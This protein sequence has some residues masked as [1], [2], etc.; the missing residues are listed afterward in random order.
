[1]VL[2]QVQKPS[3][4]TVSAHADKMGLAHPF[5]LLRSL[6]GPAWSQDLFSLI[7]GLGLVHVEYVHIIGP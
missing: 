6:H 4:L 2:D 5:G 1:M 3:G 7:H